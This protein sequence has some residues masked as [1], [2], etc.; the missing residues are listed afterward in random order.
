MNRTV[1]IMAMMNEPKQTDPKLFPSA[2]RNEA[3]VAPTQSAALK[4]HRPTTPQIVMCRTLEMT[5]EVQYELKTNPMRRPFVASSGNFVWCSVSNL[6]QTKP[7]K[8]MH[9]KRIEVKRELKVTHR[10]P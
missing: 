2:C 10:V 3:L 7:T 6:M 5:A 1:F 9:E 8:M 4:Y